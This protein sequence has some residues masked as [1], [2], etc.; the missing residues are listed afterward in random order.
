MIIGVT[1][2]Q[3]HFFSTTDGHSLFDHPPTMSGSCTQVSRTASKKFR[4]GKH[5]SFSWG[6]KHCRIY[7]FPS[8]NKT[9]EYLTSMYIHTRA[10]WFWKSICSLH[11]LSYTV[12]AFNIYSII[13]HKYW[14]M[15][16]VWTKFLL[17]I[18]ANCHILQTLIYIFI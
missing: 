2:L 13:S 18:I 6:L 9:K 14:A 7:W 11:C 16:L 17:S 8:T 15:F 3:S 4:K 1:Y 12:S 10:S 5:R